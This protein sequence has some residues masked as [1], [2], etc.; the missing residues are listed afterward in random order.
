[1]RST[2][3][4]RL[5]LLLSVLLVLPFCEVPN[6]AEETVSV[7]TNWHPEEGHPIYVIAAPS[8]AKI[9]PRLLDIPIVS[10]RTTHSESPSEA[11]LQ[12]P[13]AMSGDRAMRIG[14]GL[15]ADSAVHMALA[16]FEVAQK[17]LPG[18][19]EVKTGVAHCYYELKRD[20]E[21]LAIYK[22]VIAQNA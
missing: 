8:Q 11:D 9:P 13:F 2:N 3:Y 1:M 4:R 20:D 17:E 18:S 10:T 7:I 19:L 14:Y 6:H 12:L 16:Y 22:E 15:L 21:A 5:A